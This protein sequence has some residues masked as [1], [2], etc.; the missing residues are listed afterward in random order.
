[1]YLIYS[2]TCQGHINQHFYKCI[3]NDASFQ[4]LSLGKV[5]NTKHRKCKLFCLQFCFLPS[6]HLFFCQALTVT[7]IK[8][9]RLLVDEA[10]EKTDRERIKLEAERFEYLRDIGNLLHPSVPV[11]NDEVGS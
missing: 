8:K 1:M 6:L 4:L 10:V 7:Q 9:V 11:S 3:S 2:S 5:E